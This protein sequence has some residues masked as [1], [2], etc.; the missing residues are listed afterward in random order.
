MKIS[1]VIISAGIFLGACNKFNDINENPNLPTVATN[2]QLISNSELYLQNIGSSPQAEY[3]AQYLSETQYPNLSLYTQV[4]ASFYGYYQGPLMNLESVL[5]TEEYDAKEGPISNQIA[6][7]K[8]LKAYYMWHITDRWGDVPFTEA[9]KG[10][11]NFTP[12]YD[13]QKLI[14]DSLFKSLDEADK[15]IVTGKISNDILYN[16]DSNSW[17]KLANTIRLLMA[18][19]LTG[20][21]AVKGKDEFNKAI[22]AGIMTSNAD[23][24]VYK[25]LPNAQNENYWY[26]QVFDQKRQWWAL[27]LTLVDKMKP[28]S[29]PRLAVYGNK[30]SNGDYV[31]LPF[32]QTDNL[33]TT[34]YSLLGN[35][36]WKQDAPIYLVTYAQALFA[37]A[38]AAKLGWISGGDTKAEEYYN[39]AIQNS[40]L[41][42]TGSTT[43]ASALYN[44]ATVKYNSATALEQIATQ[45]W[46]HLFMHGFEAWAEW[47][48]TGYPALTSPQGNAV[49]TRQGYPVDEQ[50]NNKTNYQDAVQ[51]QFSGSD[52]LYGKLWWDK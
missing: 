9:L 8:I 21:D 19:R 14:Y 33:S 5:H 6:V 4:S 38:E 2:T 37:L 49:P 28:A 20:V 35:A 27:S 45:R 36:I 44:H 10:R 46:V 39:L 32:G 23:N 16:G 3:F 43:G 7:A 31:G 51:R 42:W 47:R 26:D 40:V 34:A 15:M 30:N 24:M 11:E 17:K 41:Q 48:R 13:T 50:F 29:D 18:L 52:G 25:H 1:F 22:A 12:K